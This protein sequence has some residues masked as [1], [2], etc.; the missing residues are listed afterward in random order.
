[1]GAR[2][3]R[4]LYGRHAAQERALSRWWPDDSV[5]LDTLNYGGQRYVAGRT[6]YTV[7]ESSRWGVGELDALTSNGVVY[8]I[9]RTRADLFSQVKFAWRRFGSGPRPMTS[10]LF[11]DAALAPLDNADEILEW[12]ELDA[13]SAGNSFWVMDGGELHRLPPRW[14]SI[15]LG[16]DREPDDPH[17]AWDA[18]P[19]G[20]IY[21]PEGMASD[22][23]EVFDWSEVVHYCPER[24]PHARWRGMSYLRPAMEDVASDNSARRYLTKFFDNNATPNM[25]VVFPPEVTKEVVEAFRDM[26]LEKHRGVHRAF[27]T[28]FLGGGADLKVVGVNL[29]DLDTENVRD[30]IHTDIAMAA[31]INPMAIGLK[32]VNYSNT[33]EGNRSLSD[34][35]LRYLW[36]RA[37]SALRPVIGPVPQGATLW[38]DPSGISALQSDAI[39]DAQ[40]MQ[41]KLTSIEIGIR[42][43]LDPSSVISGVSTGDDTKF[44]H[45]GL[46]SVQL[47]APGAAELPA[48][49]G[50]GNG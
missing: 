29:K 19:V 36:M 50:A 34:R 11:T 3:D 2:L 7:E 48:T 8:G 31:G 17:L 42:A 22:R 20:L 41:T 21:L 40:V 13:A 46:V 37:V 39:D 16:S 43:G 12:F 28:A 45:T 15:V 4:F 5:W 18:R 26:F 49:N 6:T 47:Q 30:Q 23:A 38:Y 44:K 35:K 24:D 27:R 9:V 32:E 1:M 14:C 33:K 25:A 10:D